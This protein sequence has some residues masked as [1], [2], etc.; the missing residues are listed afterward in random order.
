MSSPDASTESS[1]RTRVFRIVLALLVAALVAAGLLK[2]QS[3]RGMRVAPPAPRA[4]VEV[5]PLPPLPPSEL[6]LM[7]VYHAGDLLE[8][9]E[10]NVPLQFGDVEV[11]HEHPS[12]PGLG[13]AFEA[14]RDRFEV[15]VTADTLHLST[16]LRYEGHGWYDPP[17]LPQVSGG[18]PARGVGPAAPLRGGALPDLRPR[19]RV[20]L[21]TPL[22]LDSDWAL[23]TE[24][25]VAALE[26]LS[27]GERDR[28]RITQF[29]LDLTDWLMLLVREMLEDLTS[30]LDRQA[31][32]VDVRPALAE[33][34]L[35]LHR[36]MPVAEG[37]WLRLAPEG[38]R[39]GPLRVA[40][41][42]GGPPTVHLPL[43]L[44]VRPLLSDAPPFAEQV[45][46][47][48]ELEEG[49]VGGERFRI[50]AESRLSY[51]LLSGLL[52]TELEGREFSERGRTVRIRGAE[53]RGLGD[54]RLLLELDVDGDVRGRLFVVGTPSHDAEANEIHLPDLEV[55]V[56]T[57]NLLVQMAAWALRT[58]LV[59]DL[60][61]RARWPLADVLSQAAVAVGT[62][63]DR[64]LGPDTWLSGQ[65]TGLEV[66]ALQAA[67]DALVVR[68]EVE[69][70]ARLELGDF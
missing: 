32:E 18:C 27:A 14:E 36:P 31:A 61:A 48:P 9:V 2:V 67:R 23:A 47:L 59:D 28:C 57:R 8:Q 60:Q 20:T 70:S 3:E 54:G 19:A 39:R 1:Q 11:R 7:L 29:Q 62:A 10:T 63:L 4:G 38:V 55:H 51:P 15:G 37:F 17:F 16:I 26:P 40:T 66:N 45:T 41:E 34:W 53:V 68:V 21:S 42:G 49:P 50:V 69:G 5:Q 56:A 13:Y 65:V 35:Q 12:I 43:Q 25:D 24:I 64:Q 33:P 22:H 6:D 44:Q 30:E 58:G 46:A 52:A